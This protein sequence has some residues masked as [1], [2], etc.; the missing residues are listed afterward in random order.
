MFRAESLELLASRRTR[1]TEA[2]AAIAPPLGGD[3]PNDNPDL[4]DRSDSERKD[5]ALSVTLALPPPSPD[6]SHFLGGRPHAAA[7][8]LSARLALL[9]VGCRLGIHPSPDTL[10][11][12]A[13]CHNV[14][15]VRRLLEQAYGERGLSCAYE[16]AGR[17]QPHKPA[18]RANAVSAAHRP[19]G[20][21]DL[22]E[23]AV[24]RSMPLP[25]ARFFLHTPRD[26]PR[27]RSCLPASEQD[28]GSWVGG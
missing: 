21:P 28:D 26:P 12:A 1:K 14:A 4:D 22:L 16:L 27:W 11:E 6:W 7:S 23:P 9:A 13:R 8:A 20:P 24:L 10:C 19:A 3:D 5:P 15:A 25:V 17:V 18:D 2:A